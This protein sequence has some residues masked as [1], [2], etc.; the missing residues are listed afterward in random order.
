MRTMLSLFALLTCG[1]AFAQDRGARGDDA[2][3]AT[4]DAP[5]VPPPKDRLYYTNATFARVN[6][7]GLVDVFKVGWRR[8]L[9]TKDSIL[10]QDTYVFTG[11][12]AMV[13]PAYSRLGW[14]A[15]AQ[16][17]SVLRVF[18]QVEG[19]GYYGTFDQVIGYQGDDR[20]SDQTNQAL[21]EQGLSRGETGWVLTFGGTLRAKVGP[22]AARSTLSVTRYDLALND[23][24]THFYDQLWD[25]LAPDGGFMALNDLD[26]LYVK[27][28]LRLGPRYT[29]SDTLDGSG[30]STDGALAHHR[31]GPLFAWQFNDKAPGARVNQPTLFVLAQ[32]WL[33]HPYRTGNEQPQ[34]LPLVAIGF[35]FNGD[36]KTSAIQQ[37]APIP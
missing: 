20:Y 29:W 14:Y 30:D 11:P 23:D 7:L 6:P 24:E 17:L 5:Y 31:L 1:S 26:V 10:F 37:P 28:K 36:L 22:I 21:S 35:A 33:Q 18:G 4:D 13:T 15:E 34:G 3:Y 16:A 2:A 25:R 9:S 8:R 27:G 19:V 32:W 12:I